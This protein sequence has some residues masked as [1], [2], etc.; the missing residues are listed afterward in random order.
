MKET[1]QNISVNAPSITHLL[2][3]FKLMFIKK[4]AFLLTAL[5]LISGYSF[6][7][8]ITVRGKVLENGTLTPLVGATVTVV[9][10]S[11]GTVAGAGGIFSIKASVGD[12]L[13]VEHVGYTKTLVPITN[14]ADITV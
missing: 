3:K 10:K 13:S 5:L 14:S 9:G 8:Q 2:T 12:Q 11:G 7:Q 1:S 4:I 6:G